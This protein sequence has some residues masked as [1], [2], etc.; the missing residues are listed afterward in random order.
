MPD[1]FLA[2]RAAKG[3]CN[4][5]LEKKQRKFMRMNFPLL[6]G[7]DE[8]VSLFEHTWVT[9]AERYRIRRALFSFFA[10]RD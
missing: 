7:V 4:Y 5:H 1:E 8:R 2:R 10:G 9:F 3:A 6:V